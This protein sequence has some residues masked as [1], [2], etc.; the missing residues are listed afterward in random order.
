MVEAAERSSQTGQAVRLDGRWSGLVIHR[1][2]S[3][4]GGEI[5]A[6]GT[7]EGDMIIVRHS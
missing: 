2:R 1:I 7:P 5:G 4:T 6:C 3:T